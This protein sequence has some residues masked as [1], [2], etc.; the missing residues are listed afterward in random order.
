[1]AVCNLFNDLE[2]ASGNETAVDLGVK[3][4]Q[5]ALRNAKMDASDVDLIIAAASVPAQHG[6]AG[7]SWQ[8]PDPR[9]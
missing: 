5:H 4:A 9:R 1:M 2:S 8:F 7:T 3:A 6:C